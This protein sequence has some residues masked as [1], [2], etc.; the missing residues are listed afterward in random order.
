MK[1]IGRVLNVMVCVVMI[2]TVFAVAV[3]MPANV[4]VYSPNSQGQG[5]GGT[6][7]PAT[8]DLETP[9][10]TQVM[11]DTEP[12]EAVIH[13][14]TGTKEIVVYGIDDID[15]DV[16]VTSTIISTKPHKILVSYTL[17]DDAGNTMD[18]TLEYKSRDGNREVRVLEMSYNGGAPFVLGENHYKV[19]FKL[20][21]D[22][23]E[24]SHYHQ[25]LHVRDKFK[26]NEQYK[27]KE[28]ETAIEFNE[29]GLGEF[30]YEVEGLGLF[31]LM[32]DDGELT[33]ILLI[34][35]FEDYDQ[36]GL[37]NWEELLKYGTDPLNPDTD[38]D[39]L[40]D[41][42][43]VI[44]FLTNPRSSDSDYDGLFD[45]AEIDTYFTNPKDPD[46]DADGLSDYVEVTVD[47]SGRLGDQHTDP[48][49][50]DTDRDGLTDGAEVNTYNSDPRD[51]DEDNNDIIDYWD[52][53]NNGVEGS[54]TDSDGDLA[55]DVL[56]PMFAA[57]AGNKLPHPPA[58][59]PP[60][61]RTCMRTNDPDSDDDGIVDGIEIAFFIV[62]DTGDPTTYQDRLDAGENPWEESGPFGPYSAYTY[63]SIG[64]YS[65][66]GG[67][68]YNNIHNG[69]W[70]ID[71]ILDGKQVDSDNDGLSDWKEENSNW[72]YA[73]SP[74]AGKSYTSSNPH[75]PT[76]L[77][78]LDIVD[79][80]S[81]PAVDV[82][83]WSN[84]IAEFEAAF[85]DSD[86]APFARGAMGE[87]KAG[88]IYPPELNLAGAEV[89]T[90][91]NDDDEEGYD[92]DGNYVSGSAYSVRN[93]TQSGA[94]NALSKTKDY[95]NYYHVYMTRSQAN[96]QTITGKTYSEDTI[97]RSGSL[98]Y[99]YPTDWYWNN[100]SWVG[101]PNDSNNLGITKDR[102]LIKTL[103]HEVGHGLGAN[104]D[105]DTDGNEPDTINF[106]NVMISS[107]NLNENDRDPWEKCYR[108]STGQG[109]YKNPTESLGAYWS[110]SGTVEH[111]PRFS[112]D[113]WNQISFAWKRSVESGHKN[114]Y[115]DFEEYN[116][117]G[118][119]TYTDGGHHWHS[120]GPETYPGF[121]SIVG[122]TSSGPRIS[123][124]PMN[125][126]PKDRDWSIPSQ[127]IVSRGLSAGFLVERIVDDDSVVGAHSKT[128]SGSTAKLYQDW[129]DVPED[130]KTYLVITGMAL[131]EIHDSGGLDVVVY[132]SDSSTSARTMGFNLY[133]GDSVKPYTVS[134]SGGQAPETYR[135]FNIPSSFITSHGFLVIEFDATG[136][137]KT[138]GI[139]GLWIQREAEV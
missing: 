136:T 85:E 35:G 108:G 7:D 5:L 124:W 122:S 128:S 73:H 3:P 88:T 82:A 86:W 54:Y 131:S 103:I 101:N 76:L 112:Y 69:D 47:R 46:T 113:S 111:A 58:V 32:T 119:N 118:T 100:H 130:E 51:K 89:I 126:L 75:V 97:K 10:S 117:Q 43:E 95:E 123:N 52:E 114:I 99:D 93:P 16:E 34:D 45:Q 138:I 96:S 62:M 84:F 115:I 59:L 28:N 2:T 11:A 25:N 13:W 78:E 36:D 50:P 129:L 6:S 65:I 18:L 92:A 29:K 44:A 60:R 67:I 121:K 37:T 53:T 12:P 109:S 14:D 22:T 24:I 39:G 61:P 137:Y 134:V 83:S 9:T 98:V 66:S 127:D 33:L 8:Y 81:P 94:K 77:V 79:G 15:A 26:I 104:H 116:S 71:G 64:I 19:E 91:A 70:E 27:A 120:I 106:Y 80:G 74:S 87:I 23:D 139:A 1:S 110:A 21:K 38:G 17:T 102:L 125:T 31:D 4:G 90:Y 63:A 57:C 49:N 133:N 48:T 20:E 107:T 56:E 55:W 42:A 132:L 68:Y 30:H 105:E 72:W 41:G 135:S 40:S